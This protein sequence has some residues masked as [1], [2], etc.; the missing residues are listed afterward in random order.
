LS[1]PPN[2]VGVLSSTISRI[3]TRRSGREPSTK[4][5]RDPGIGRVT[6]SESWSVCCC[7]G[8]GTA[9][10][11]IVLGWRDEAAAQAAGGSPAGEL[12]RDG[13]AVRLRSFPT[14]VSAGSGSKGLSQPRQA[15]YPRFG[16]H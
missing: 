12:L 16:V 8:E 3:G 14:P 5:L 9:F 2:R 13:D 7:S 10:I 15:W 4:I 6:V 1:S 11:G